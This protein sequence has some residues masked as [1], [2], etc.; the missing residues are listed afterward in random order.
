MTSAPARIASIVARAEPSKS[1]RLAPM[2]STT[3]APGRA[4]ALQIRGLV[5]LTLPAE[6]IAVLVE[7]EGTLACTTRDLE[8]Q[9]G[10]MRALDVVV[11]IGRR[12]D[13]ATVQRLHRG[14]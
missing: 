4:Q 12:E 3:C 5:L 6:E 10:E 1:Q 2:T 11:E 8:R 14:F 9:R 7:D 13:Q